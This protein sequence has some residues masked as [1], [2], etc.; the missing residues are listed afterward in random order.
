LWPVLTFQGLQHRLDAQQLGVNVA[1]E[2]FFGRTF[3]D[4]IRTATR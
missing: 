2:L 4:A 3:M 1:L